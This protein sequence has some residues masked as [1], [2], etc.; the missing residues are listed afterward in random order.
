ML[1]L[2]K[3]C[4]NDVTKLERILGNQMRQK[5]LFEDDIKNLKVKTKSQH[6]IQFRGIMPWNDKGN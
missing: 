5:R 2:E 1:Q 6:P 3:T 4:K